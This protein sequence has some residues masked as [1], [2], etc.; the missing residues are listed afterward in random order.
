M[1]A[2]SPPLGAI[3]G[4]AAGLHFL[5]REISYEVLVFPLERD[6]GGMSI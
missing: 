3:R 5:A 4:R 2:T 1:I 6:W